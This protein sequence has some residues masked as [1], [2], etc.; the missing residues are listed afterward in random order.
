MT[1]YGA[2][3]GE[4]FEDFFIEIGKC[5]FLH[6]YWPACLWILRASWILLAFFFYELFRKFCIFEN[7]SLDSGCVD[8]FIKGFSIMCKFAHVKKFKIEILY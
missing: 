1:F 8:D 4:F 2:L 7:F 6:V 5:F 3:V